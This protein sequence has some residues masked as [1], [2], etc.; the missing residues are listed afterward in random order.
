MSSTGRLPV[1]IWTTILDLVIHVQ[2][3]VETGCTKESFFEF[4]GPV[5]EIYCPLEDWKVS[6]K[7]RWLLARVCRSWKE[8][9]ESRRYR[10]I[11]MGQS[12]VPQSAVYNAK[13]V[14]LACLSPDIQPDKPSRWVVIDASIHFR[15]HFKY[16]ESFVQH[17]QLHPHFRR[18]NL[19]LGVPSLEVQSILRLLP[20]FAHLTYLLLDFRRSKFS[21]RLSS[22]S[23]EPIATLPHV[24]VFEWWPDERDEYPPM[25]D[26]PSLQH[27]RYQAYF[28]LPEFPSG[29]LTPSS[30][31]CLRSLLLSVICDGLNPFAILWSSFPCLEEL[32][33]INF[34]P[35]FDEPLPPQ[36]PLKRVWFPE[37]WTFRVYKSLAY[38]LL[39]LW[40]SFNSEHAPEANPRRDI[41]ICSMVWG[42][43]GIPSRTPDGRRWADALEEDIEEM[44]RF[45]RLVNDCA[46][47]GVRTLDRNYRNIRE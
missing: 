45:C 4:F 10:Y 37:E 34:R 8:W 21:S 46:R 32:V 17:S 6:E 35:C 39:D 3:L 36:H 9:A 16:F 24:T 14:P 41:H 26:L 40:G 19:T 47:W 42:P 38:S 15:S 27:M 29:W 44:E 11:Q 7:Q 23:K 25:L 20:S 28:T 33:C 30:R 2:R 1:E 13:R 43:S 18:L 5:D 22:P 31:R 12:G